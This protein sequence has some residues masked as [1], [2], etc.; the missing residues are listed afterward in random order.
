MMDLLIVLLVLLLCCYQCQSI[1]VADIQIDKTSDQCLRR[2][3]YITVSYKNDLLH[4]ELFFLASFKVLENVMEN[5]L[6]ELDI[7]ESEKGW[8]FHMYIRTVI[9]LPVVR[10]L[11]LLA[12]EL[13]YTGIFDNI[14]DKKKYTESSLT[15]DHITAICIKILWL[16]LAVINF[17]YCSMDNTRYFFIDDKGFIDF[18]KITAY[19]D[20]PYINIWV[21][22]IYPPADCP[23]ILKNVMD[24]LGRLTLAGLY[25]TALRYSVIDS[26]HKWTGIMGGHPACFKVF[27]DDET[28]GHFNSI[29]VNNAG[30]LTEI[31]KKEMN[32]TIKAV[33]IFDDLAGPIFKKL[34][35]NGE[36]K[37]HKSS[38]NYRS[39]KKPSNAIEVPTML[40]AYERILAFMKSTTEIKMV[41]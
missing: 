32:E 9:L 24:S 8:G 12:S 3:L 2:Y 34:V 23:G 21:Q 7:S 29:K 5:A 16:F 14:N 13:V 28:W 41:L 33:Y 35:E 25:G 6:K 37:L 39:L 19:S 1:K 38:R 20:I 31:E 22:V 17:S 36:D 30:P 4:P 27:T 18:S 10:Y 11:F 15:R 26:K 40:N